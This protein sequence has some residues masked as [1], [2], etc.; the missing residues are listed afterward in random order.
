M[1]K[2]GKTIYYFCVPCQKDER[3]E[4]FIDSGGG[5]RHFNEDRYPNYEKVWPN[6]INSENL[7]GFICSKQHLNNLHWSS[8]N[9]Y[10]SNDSVGLRMKEPIL[11][12]NEF[13]IS[14][15]KCQKREIFEDEF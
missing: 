14:K 5:L 2:K 6:L 15:F 1:K 9:K 12:S 3:K 7:D 4:K 10:L 13:K 11:E 8:K